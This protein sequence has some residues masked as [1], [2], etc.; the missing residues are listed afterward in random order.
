[1]RY[2]RG[3]KQQTGEKIVR[4]AGRLFRNNG[5]AATGVDAVMASVKLTAGGFY[6]HF[7]S[8]E[9][10]LAATLDNIFRE[11]S[12][13]R[14]RQLS[15]LKGSAWL[16]AFVSFYLSREHRDTPD[17]G[18]PMPALAAEVARIGGQP[19][20][21]FEQHLRRIVDWMAQQFERHPDNRERAITLLAQCLGG[22]MLARAVED[23]SF[24]EEI[25]GACRDSI[26]KQ[27]G[28]Q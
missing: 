27:I 8:K 26:T 21:V 3:H 6:S 16:Q 5:F 12:Q 2:P 18:C 23:S 22:L 13:D 10:L 4:S 15:E 24:S 11:S 28:S 20:V 1:V 9:E 7:G 14:P 25:L 19:R 17:K